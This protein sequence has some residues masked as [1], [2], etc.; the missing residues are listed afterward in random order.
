MNRHPAVIVVIFFKGVLHLGPRRVLQIRLYKYIYASTTMR[1]RLCGYDYASMHVLV[2]SDCYSGH[3]TRR[4]GRT[5]I[6]YA[7]P[8]G[9]TSRYYCLDVELVP[10]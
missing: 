10:L 5:R 2:L 3:V 1:V 7:T 6:P 9:G 4:T 8:A